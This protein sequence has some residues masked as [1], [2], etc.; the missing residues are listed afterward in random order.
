MDRIEPDAANP[1]AIHNAC[2]LISITSLSRLVSAILQIV[3]FIEDGGDGGDR[4]ASAAFRCTA[5]RSVSVRPPCLSVWNA[6]ENHRVHSEGTKL[7]DRLSG[8]FA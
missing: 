6:G 8:G 1:A 5:N 2:F 3:H 4:G 7:G